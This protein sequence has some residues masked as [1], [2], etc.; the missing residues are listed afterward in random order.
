MKYA[1][2]LLILNLVLA[3]SGTKHIPVKTS[4]TNIKHSEN[5]IDTIK[6][7]K[8]ETTAFVETDILKNSVN[9]VKEQDTS[10]HQ[11]L[12]K[13]ELTLHEIW[14]ELLQ[15]NVS[16]NGN[17]NYNSFKTEHKKLLG[18]IYLLNL[19]QQK[20]ILQT[21]SKEEK[22]VYW[23]NTY[24]AMTI[25]LILRHYPVK[26]IKDIKD[27]W[28]QRYWKLGEKWYN[29]DD[30]EHQILRKMNEP[31]IHFAIVCASVSC[32][33]LANEAYTTEKLEQQLTHATKDFLNDTSKNSINE[34]N[35]ELSKIFKW[36]SSDFTKNGT[37][38]DFL[39]LY[40]PIEISSKASKSFKD[41]NWD[42]ND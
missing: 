13:R 8:K 21:F 18:Y 20:N 41:Y 39:N 22:L 36:F 38:I 12:T 11:K 23:I 19:V 6:I 7:T 16:S 40:S 30:I 34:D 26:S 42:L 9:T 24:N 5:S 29:L 4:K 1:P 37:L 17:V 28:Q 15:N 31:R 25:D 14:N 27:P 2:F 33:K 32:P 10:F 35:L 3:C